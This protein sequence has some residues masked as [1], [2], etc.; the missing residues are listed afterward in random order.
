[1]KN[2]RQSYNTHTQH[3]SLWVKV[4]LSSENAR[5]FYCSIQ[6]S[7]TITPQKVVTEE[8]ISCIQAFQ[9][10][11]ITRPASGK[12][13]ATVNQNNTLHVPRRLTHVVPSPVRQT[14]ASARSRWQ[15]SSSVHVARGR[16]GP[17][18]PA[19]PAGPRQ[20]HS[21]HAIAGGGGGGEVHPPAATPGP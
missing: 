4:G 2:H 12:K 6:T 20:T 13:E 1:M 3:T 15:R 19:A 21:S 11:T 16:A 9:S 8:R 18:L 5:P 14:D 17:S 7:S 10:L